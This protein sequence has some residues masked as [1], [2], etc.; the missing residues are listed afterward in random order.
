M[1]QADYPSTLPKSSVKKTP[2]RSPAKTPE[3]SLAKAPAKSP[4]KKTS[5]VKRTPAKAN[6]TKK[7]VKNTPTKVTK[8]T[9]TPAKKSPTKKKVPFHETWL[10]SVHDGSGSPEEINDLLNKYSEDLK[11]IVDAYVEGDLEV[12]ATHRK[13]FE[14]AKTIKTTIDDIVQNQTFETEPFSKSEYRRFTRL[15]S[16]CQGAITATKR[17]GGTSVKAV[18]GAPPIPSLPST[19]ASPS[20]AP[21]PSPKQKKP[22]TKELAEGPFIC[23]WNSDTCGHECET[24]YQLKTHILKHPLEQAEVYTCSWGKN[25]KCLFTSITPLTMKNHIWRDHLDHED[26]PYVGSVDEKWVKKQPPFK[27]LAAEW[28]AK[29]VPE[30]MHKGDTR[31]SPLSGEEW[32]AD[33]PPY[34]LAG[35][36]PFTDQVVSDQ[37][38][39][40]LLNGELEELAHVPRRH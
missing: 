21:S 15:L 32:W 33:V 3:R 22:A 2:A 18:H 9:I 1:G 28:K 16:Q 4:V 10:E 6:E 35:D 34:Y 37:M 26:R 17:A 36:T 20:P 39:L 23:E 13:V 31:V 29:G 40:D 25:S 5:P 30:H 11:G 27:K 12:E 38:T 8:P 14:E 7:K 19:P 24:R